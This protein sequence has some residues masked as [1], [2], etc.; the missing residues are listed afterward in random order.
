MGVEACNPS[1]IDQAFTVKI[2]DIYSGKLEGH[3]NNPDP[4]SGLIF[5]IV[6]TPTKGV[7]NLTSTSEGTF[8]Y[9]PNANATGADQFKFKVNDG[10]HDSLPAT[11]TIT[12]QQKP[13]DFYINLFGDSD[14]TLPEGLQKILTDNTELDQIVGGNA[15][16]T[17]SAVGNTPIGDRR[18]YGVTENWGVLQVTEGMENNP[19]AVASLLRFGINDVHQYLDL[20]V[21]TNDPTW[22]NKFISDY[23]QAIQIVVEAGS[24]PILYE[25]HYENLAGYDNTIDWVN[26]R[27]NEFATEFGGAVVKNKINC[28]T[29]PQYC[30]SDRVH[31]NIAGHQYLSDLTMELFRQGN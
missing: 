23:R 28:R 7:L 18:G 9:K 15:I 11:V 25:L 21:D 8:T 2:G 26:A 3:N 29:Q 6:T 31:L 5:S 4:N 22:K 10:L 24:I 16:I 13:Q 1:A 20:A 19:P 14:S 17:N 27:V 30:E 12:L